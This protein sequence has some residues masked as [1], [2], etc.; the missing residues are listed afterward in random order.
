MILNASLLDDA[1]PVSVMIEARPFPSPS[2]SAAAYSVVVLGNHGLPG[3]EDLQLLERTV[4]PDIRA[5]DLDKQ[6][7]AFVDAIKL[8]LSYGGKH[9]DFTVYPHS[10]EED[11]LAWRDYVAATIIKIGENRISG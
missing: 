1:R 9:V 2:N 8:G 7:N 5:M 11:R 3:E 10:S 4:A 6:T